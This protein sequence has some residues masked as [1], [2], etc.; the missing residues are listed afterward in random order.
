FFS[1]ASLPSRSSSL[2]LLNTCSYSLTT[3][4]CSP[5]TLGMARSRACPCRKCGYTVYLCSR[6]RSPCCT[7][8]TQ[9]ANYE[10]RTHLNRLPAIVYWRSQGAMVHGLPSNMRDN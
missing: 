5:G 8:Y 6:R 1:S 7:K 4:K 3:Q 10:T 9:Q 2:W